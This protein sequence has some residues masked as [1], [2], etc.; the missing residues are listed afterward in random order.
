MNINQRNKAIALELWTMLDSDPTR[1]I[2]MLDRLVEWQGPEPLG[3]MQ[4]AE[5]AIEGMFSPLL[6]SIPDLKRETHIFM[7]GASNAQE[8]EAEDGAHWV[9]GTGYYTGRAVCEAFGIPA[10]DADLRI[11]WGEFLRFNTEG[12]ITHAQTIWDFVDWFDQIGLPVLP[13]PRGTAHVYPAPTAYD[14][15]RGAIDDQAETDQ[16]MAL[17]RGLIFGGLNSFDKSD[18]G[19]MGMARFFHPNVKWYGPG[20]IGACLSLQEFETRHQ[21]PWLVAFPDRKVM[22]LESLFAED[23]LVAASGPMGVVATHTGPYLDQPASQNRIEVSGI[24]FW[25]RTGDKFTENW[26]FVDM[27][28]LFSQMGVD[29][30]ARMKAQEVKR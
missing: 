9:A 3:V 19:S 7:G 16:S 25:L 12:H 29:L 30:F 8:V 2:P 15:V 1:T 24:D 22:H 17:G 4:G 18:L 20:G 26:V 11:R 28:H 14:G 10:T 27:I 6:R 13:K 5:A 23:R 21:Q